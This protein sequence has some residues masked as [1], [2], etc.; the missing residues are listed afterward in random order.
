V[1]DPTTP[2]IDIAPDPVTVA[3]GAGL[4]DAARDLTFDEIPNV[5]APDL[6]GETVEQS[7]LVRFRKRTTVL[8]YLATEP[9]TLNTV[10]GPMDFVAGDWILT[11]EDGSEIWPV[12]QE[13]IDANYERVDE[14]AADITDGDMSALP[15]A[16]VTV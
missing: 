4:P 13:Y 15:T 3:A 2:A 10:R 8:G 14:I 1:T 5:Q 7:D 16:T 6:P 9:G 11:P 12:S